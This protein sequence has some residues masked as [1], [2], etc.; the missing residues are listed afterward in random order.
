VQKGGALA[1]Y[2]WGIARKATLLDA[3]A[4]P[5]ARHDGQTSDKTTADMDHA[6]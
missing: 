2:R 5:E 1:G 6:A 4:H 3:E